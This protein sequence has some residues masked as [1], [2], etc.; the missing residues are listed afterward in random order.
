M[1]LLNAAKPDNDQIENKI[2]FLSSS[3]LVLI[4]TGDDVRRHNQQCKYKDNNDMAH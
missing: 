3:K 4:I 1:A 2:D